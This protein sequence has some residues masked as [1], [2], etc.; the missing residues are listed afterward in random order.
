[1]KNMLSG[2]KPNNIE[3]LYKFSNAPKTLVALSLTI[4]DKHNL[5]HDDEF[6]YR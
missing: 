1:M 2:K 6:H 3:F 4:L 5:A